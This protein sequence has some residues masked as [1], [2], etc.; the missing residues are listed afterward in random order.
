MRLQESTM[1]LDELTQRL[2]RIRDQNDWKQFHS[3]KN[4]AMA[5]SVEMAELVEIFQWLREDQSRE[6][7]ADQREH[8][9]QEVGDIV[10]YLLLLC[11]ELG[12][13]MET[14]VRNKLADSER[15]F[16]K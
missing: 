11:S 10:L 16:A 12:L 1:N 2:H 8:A 4:L 13:D 14:V 9:G 6:L 5:A 15:R 7:P 3:P